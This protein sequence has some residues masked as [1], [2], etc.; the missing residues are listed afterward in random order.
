MKILFLSAYYPPNVRG[1]AEISTR[2]LAEGLVH[3]GHNVVVITEGETRKTVDV[4]GV[5]VNMMPLGLTAKPLFEKKES[6]RIAGAIGGA[7]NVDAFDAI[8]AHDFRSAMALSELGCKNAMVTARDYAQVCGTTN[9]VIYSGDRCSC[10]LGD[11]L[12]TQRIREASLARKPFR[13]WQY[14][15]NFL[16]RKK[17]FSKIKTQ[18]FI[19][20]AQKKEIEDQQDLSD[21]SKYVV[22]NPVSRD[23][24]NLPCK[25]G[26]RGQVLYVGTVEDYKGVGLLISA[27]TEVLEKC[28]EASLKIV[29]EGAQ[30]S[31]YVSL[32]NKTGL[33]KNVNFVGRIPHRKLISFYDEAETVVAPHLWIEPFGRTVAEA[34]ARGKVVVAADRGGPSEMIQDGVSGWLF[35]RGVASD[36]SEKICRVVEM[37]EEEKENIGKKAHDWAISNLNQEAVCA[38][39][40]CVYKRM[41]RSRS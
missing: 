16:Y 31:D 41:L 2:L 39:Y 29:G 6:K 12:K 30:K 26:K 25:K 32:V 8:H 9:N 35:K 13:L 21:I 11:L 15:Y 38:Q 20:N 14:K 17:A 1:G 23:Y 3:Q 37:T 28:P 34:M 36:L 7:F 18:V 27:W 22:Y 10:S 24:L 33:D 40:E 4:D 19:S 5:E